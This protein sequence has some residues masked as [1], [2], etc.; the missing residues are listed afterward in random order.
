MQNAW[1][2][3]IKFDS[4]N[5]ICS[6]TFKAALTITRITSRKNLNLLWT[7]TKAQEWEMQW[8]RHMY[9]QYLVF[10]ELKE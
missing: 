9:R 6:S 3:Y 2:C 8:K 7:L 10:Y 1:Q 5:Y 4:Y